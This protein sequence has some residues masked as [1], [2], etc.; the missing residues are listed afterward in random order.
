MEA[1][2]NVTGNGKRSY[3]RLNTLR[4]RICW[5]LTNMGQDDIRK[6]TRREALVFFNKMES[7]DIKR[8][9]GATYRSVVDYIK[10]FK[11]FW[12]WFQKREME[13]DRMVKDITIDL[14]ATERHE[15]EF[16]FFTFEELK[17]VLDHCKYEYRVYM[18]VLFDSGIRAPT[19]FM[20]LRVGD[21][22]WR[23]DSE[24]YELDIKD[25]YAKTFGRKIKL[26]L[27]SSLLSGYLSEKD[28]NA[29]FFNHDWKTFG[30]Y[31]KRVFQRILGNKAT[32]GGRMI[33][34]IRAY[35]FRHSAACYWRPIY[36][37]VNAYMYR[38]GWKE[39]RMVHYYTKFLGMEDTISQDDLLIDSEAKSKLEIELEKER[40]TRALME[41]RLKAQELQLNEIG[42]KFEQVNSFM[43]QITLREPDFIKVLAKKAKAH[44]IS[45]RQD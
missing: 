39:M 26:V 24:L 41:E 34:E 14:D 38:F 42:D 6:I 9:N 5:I 23:E 8:Q 21:F 35:D 22:H 44:E 19:E 36:K 43:N 7:G 45:F 11:A 29:P 28:P 13:Q 17:K 10:A 25:S 2:Y 3:I 18:W 27:S 15:N 37:N 31:M 30:I 16:V 40:K 20:S 12:H 32:K 1:G 33:R 4:Q